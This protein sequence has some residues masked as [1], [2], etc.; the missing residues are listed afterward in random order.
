[1]LKRSLRQI[2]R[3]SPRQANKKKGDRRRLRIELCEPRTMLSANVNI[4]AGASGSGSLD[5]AFL[6]NHGFLSFSTP[7][8]GSGANLDTLSTGALASLG[9]TQN[10]SI[11]AVHAITF[12]DLGGTFTLPI[13]AGFSA[14]FSTDDQ[15]GGAISFSKPANT[16]ASSGGAIFFDAGADLTLANIKTGGGDTFLVAG[17]QGAGTLTA[18]A[19]QTTG[20]ANGAAGNVIFT[21]DHIALTAPVNAGSGRVT[22]Q[23][24][25]GSTA[26]DLGSNTSGK[27]GLTDAELAQVSAG[28]V[29][30][31][32]STQS[33]GITFSAPITSHNGFN[34][35]SL[36][37]FG[38]IA[39]TV[40]TGT[41]L[42]TANVALR[43]GSGIGVGGT[44]TIDASNLA[45]LNE[46]N[47]VNITAP[48]SLTIGGVDGTF[49]GENPDSAST[50]RLT[51]TGPITFAA[52]VYSGLALQ[53]SANETANEGANP[54][55][56]D[57]IIDSH[58]NVGAG[59]KINISAADH[60]SIAAA[61]NL[62]APGV[63][64]T[65]GVGDTDS[66]S[67]IDALGWIAAA[68]Y[69]VLVSDGDL[70]INSINSPGAIV[71][72]VSNHGAILDANDPPV[73]TNNV[74]SATLSLQAAKGIGVTASGIDAAAAP[75]EVS[76][77]TLTVSNSTS[78]DIQ[79]VNQTGNVSVSGTN[80]APG[81]KINLTALGGGTL[82][83][84]SGNL[85]SKDGNITI[86]ADAMV[87]TGNVNAGNGAVSLKQATGSLGIDLGTNPVSGGLGL[88]QADLNHV[89]AGVL[90][91]GDTANL[92]EIKVTQSIFA[93]G[94]WNT[95]SL[96]SG[97]QITDSNLAPLGVTNLDVEGLGGVQVLD[98]AVS[99]LAGT[100][101][102]QPFVFTNQQTLTIASVD[103][104]SGINTLAAAGQSGGS[105][106][107]T[108]A[109]TLLS[110]KQPI[111]SGSSNIVLSG[112]LMS[113][114]AA[115]DAGSGRVELDAFS[116][117]ESIVLGAAATG[118]LSLLQ[119][120]LNQ[121][122]AGVL[123]IGASS[124]M[125]GIQVA[126]PI[127]SPT[128]GP[129]AWNTLDLWSNGGTI[130]SVAGSVLTAPNLA[131]HSGVA[132]G[133]NAPLEVAASKLAFASGGP[134]YVHGT[135]V[136]TIASV[137]GLNTST[138]V[139]ITTLAVSGRLIFDGLLGPGGGLTAITTETANESGQPPED[140]IVIDS[141]AVLGSNSPLS[142]N[143]ADSILINS[144]ALLQGQTVAFF[145]GAGDADQDAA[146]TN[147]GIIS[148]MDVELNA[149][150]DIT[151]GGGI[152]AHSIE[153]N[154]TAGAIVNSSSQ[155]Q[156]IAA[157]LS[158]TATTG[159]GAA[160][161]PLLTQ[162]PAVVAQTT[163]SGGIYLD[164]N[165][166]N[167][168][169][170]TIGFANDVFQGVKVLGGSGDIVLTNHGTI[171][172]TNA[173]ENV[174][175]EAATGAGNI[176]V[177]AIGAG[178]N[179]VDGGNQQAVNIEGITNKTATLI[180]DGNLVLG[181]PGQFG[182]VTGGG[183]VVLNA[184]GDI[185]LDEGSTAR[186]AGVGYGV[187]ATAG[188]SIFFNESSRMGAALIAVDKAP[189]VV[190]TGAGG[191]L[192][193]QSAAILGAIRSNS[194]D[195]TINADHV[196][197]AAGV[198][199]GNG[200][201][202][203]RQATGAEPID[204]GTNPSMGKLGI[205][206]DDL[207]QITAGVVRIGDKNNAGDIT[208]SADIV[209]PAGWKTLSLA[210]GGA[211]IEAVGAKLQV[212]N[213]AVQAAG[214]VEL[215]GGL[216]RNQISNLAGA[217]GNQ[218]ATFVVSNTIDLDVNSIDGVNGIS[219]NGGQTVLTENT[220]GTKLTVAQPIVSAGGAIDFFTDYL[221]LQAAVNAGA[222]RL[223]IASDQPQW[224]VFLG[225][226]V[227]SSL[228]LTQSD[229]NQIT[230]GVLQIDA[231][232]CT[233]GIGIN[234]PISAPHNAPGTW[235]TLDLENL[236][237]I[238]TLN[239][240]KITAPNLALRA[241]GGIGNGNATP[242]DLA[243]G[244]LAFSNQGQV[245]M[246]RNQGPLT[247]AAVDGLMTSF[248]AL[249][250][251][252]N[253][254]GG[255]LT[256]ATD[257][258][259][260]GKLTATTA[261]SATESS[262]NG[263]DDNIVVP[264]NVNVQ[265]A[266]L[267]PAQG[268]PA[269]D[270]T[271]VLQ[272]A[273][274]ISLLPKSVVRSD[275]SSVTLLAGAGDNDDDATILIQGTV[276]GASAAAKGASA[277]TIDYAN[278]ASL[279]NGLTFNGAIGASLT[280]TDHGSASAHNYLINGTSVSRDAAPLV[281]F[282]SD[283]TAVTVTGGDS[284]TAGDTFH[285]TP[286]AAVTFNI[287]GGLP[288]PPALPGD[289]LVVPPGGTLTQTIDRATGASGKW[290]FAGDKPINFSG[291]EPAA[292]AADITS[293]N[294]TTFTAGV[295]GTFTIAANGYP[296]P[297]FS[298]TGGLPAGIT[299]NGATGVLAGTPAIGSAGTYQ[300][301]ITAH[302]GQGPDTTQLFTLLVVAPAPTAKPDTFVL[303]AG[304]TSAGSGVT[305]I[306]SNDVS[307][308]GQHQ[309]LTA[310]LV[311]S[312]TH[313]T[314]T[315]NADG[316]FNYSPNASFQG[317]D[318]FTYQVN[319][320]ATAGNTV[321][322]TLLSYTA[323][324]VDK[325]YHQV[326]GRSAEDGG[327]QYW[328]GLIAA[329]QPYS[330][331]AQGIFESNERLDPIITQYYQQYLLRQADASGLAYW[332]D[333]VWKRDGGPDNVVSG[334][335][336]SAEF[337]ASAGRSHPTQ[338]PNAAWVTTL[339]ER[340]LNREPDSDGLKFWTTALDSNALTRQQVVLGFVRSSENFRNLTTAFIKQYLNRTPTDVELTHYVNEF[341]AGASQRQVELEIID[342]NEY[343]STPPA[344]AAG[345]VTLALYPH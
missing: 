125:G 327:L 51:A 74:T 172:I 245:T 154:S 276:S 60:I 266:G 136:L 255:S 320:G 247:I 269:I 146:L 198:N 15:G 132:V 210:S 297:T 33:G 166:R 5:Q 52:N 342:S 226:A 104:V 205:S 25:N 273:D 63:S 311:S 258:S 22:F 69:A 56:D 147:N 313:G 26:I 256:F 243:V 39:N 288:N 149:P 260:G 142:F 70:R 73:G 263:A 173:G 312:T 324:I 105:V 251:T 237:Q 88:S 13:A 331:V 294:S 170:L 167:P 179:I 57:V 152:T 277:L 323:S 230:A 30:V 238:F 53:V 100:T 160:N 174:A 268:Q 291:I 248:A 264:P 20:G 216:I 133:G 140:D 234:A 139:G 181:T 148:G 272:S 102:N 7:D 107:L 158:L 124:A 27:L 204:L 225:A 194:G 228:S 122:T 241:S 71:T 98:G 3:V 65:A 332:R 289:T 97:G 310:T 42:T 116:S 171:N 131:L 80:S 278:G 293:G 91:I 318:R 117:V 344:P 287:N 345:H 196:I 151:L 253:V 254:T 316:S 115:V 84:S 187:T 262:P 126:A 123:Q 130:T 162:V 235:T 227:P 250:T 231:P 328:S 21:T 164:N 207:N 29:Q 285:V 201:V 28:V 212:T 298:E 48:G 113:L 222:G 180:A 90:R 66:D 44:L 200:V 224:P 137:D 110:V 192:S 282:D 108:A 64:L 76:V 55:E 12:G 127:S 78:G 72:L 178:A 157:Q 300:I 215:V 45:Y 163:T 197:L 49:G 211:I 190:S 290:Q 203:L 114:N 46:L 275:S 317:I 191:T 214:N 343:R 183:P 16:L 208:I 301:T 195:I 17:S 95:L 1:M 99:N 159:I 119:S 143:A 280:I 189:I 218:N 75:I 341:L 329:G 118:S 155:I 322:V 4:F 165:S 308:D 267:P 50:T 161:A 199:A 284:P 305:G 144:G 68:D 185:T 338:S 239:G 77:A 134:V 334:M 34:T 43:S 128:S 233:N 23:P 330:V 296:P 321:T 169:S 24:F 36:V 281:A 92:G 153:I 168:G 292:T 193:L 9:S 8:A 221:A 309:A 270:R 6:A 315:L 274:G 58:I 38:S 96:L 89:T 59:S 62:V 261:E 325:L 150:G 271:V 213:L 182:S 220:H 340:L 101:S 111:I 223:E 337:F 54:P 37:T 217:V 306:L 184:G 283:V 103:G 81:G 18:Q 252:I 236:G 19:V 138:S 109:T 295:P 335:I 279:P 242:I 121:I 339:Y 307:N 67:S 156:L 177:H 326:L 106:K 319:E 259:V 206:Q 93:S 32:N 246:I 120:D 257:L 303:S 302:N 86:V 112:F 145:A 41:A 176:T 304:G 202:T 175:T 299:L 229:L 2:Q 87:L 14:N 240:G 333:Q 10:L 336:S 129:G 94:G 85:T 314:L 79:V 61:S 186:A 82:T 47:D 265:A 232:A 35:L 244:N 219:T 40:T 209:Q 135:G 31:G 141:A 11:Q 188:G 83:V 249:D 286:S